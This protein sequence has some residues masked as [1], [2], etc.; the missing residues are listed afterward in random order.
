[1]GFALAI[2]VLFVIWLPWSFGWEPEFDKVAM[3]VF[4]AG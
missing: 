4:F 3:D 1:M 2:A